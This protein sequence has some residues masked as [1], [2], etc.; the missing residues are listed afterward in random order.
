[1]GVGSIAQVFGSAKPRELS[2]TESTGF[3]LTEREGED[4]E[5]TEGAV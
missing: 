1:M 4:E 3:R 5:A 2:C